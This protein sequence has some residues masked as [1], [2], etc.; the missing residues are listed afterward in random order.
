MSA[1]TV[2][3]SGNLSGSGRLIQSLEHLSNTLLTLD[4]SIPLPATPAVSDLMVRPFLVRSMLEV[5]CTLLIGR[6][7]SFRLLCIAQL[8][9]QSSYDPGEKLAGAIQWSGDILSAD[10]APT[11]MWNPSKLPRDMTRALL[12]DYVNELIY[13]PAFVAML[14]ELTRDGRATSHGPWTED[15][16]N[17]EPTRLVP[18]LRSTA[19]RLYSAT[20]KGVHQEFVLSVANY[21]DR[22]TIEDLANETRKLLGTLGLVT[23]FAESALFRLPADQAIELYE[24]IQS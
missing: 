12:G 18:R 11:K 17:T 1:L 8:Q 21:Y 24:E 3:L 9:S 15:L 7:D 13:Q 2:L 10:G 19:S 6:L 22:P 4:S 20:S 5:G 16:L 14:D 23:N